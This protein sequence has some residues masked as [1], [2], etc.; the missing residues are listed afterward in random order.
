MSTRFL[1]L[2]L[3]LALLTT[4]ATHLYTT[5]ETEILSYPGSADTERLATVHGWPW[6]YYAEVTEFTPWEG[7]LVGWSEYG[8]WRLQMLGQTSLAWFVLWLVTLLIVLAVISSN[9]RRV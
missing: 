9:R 3:V 1:V 4:A 6:G 7:G 8:E 2:V 5:Q